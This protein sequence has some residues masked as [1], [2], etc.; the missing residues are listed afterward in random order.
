MLPGEMALQLKEGQKGLGNGP[1]GLG[2]FSNSDEIWTILR[3]PPRGL[4]I[5]KVASLSVRGSTGGCR[6]PAVSSLS[7]PERE[8]LSSSWAGSA[9]FD[10]TLH[11]VPV[12]K[13]LFSIRSVPL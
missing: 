5:V 4:L 8:C 9:S 7:G 11:A 2:V 3:R 13:V 12:R 6:D 1:A 10:H